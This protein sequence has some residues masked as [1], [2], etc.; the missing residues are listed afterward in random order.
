H[1]TKAVVHDPGVTAV[2]AGA[3]DTL[4]VDGS[5]T[6]VRAWDDLK[7]RIEPTLTEGRA[8]RAADEIALGAK[9]LDTTGAHVGGYVSVRGRGVV[10]RMHVVGRVVLPS[11]KFNKLGYGGVMTFAA[12][13]RLDSGAQPGLYLMR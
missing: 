4:S 5:D 13:K 11:S 7:G 2:G 1:V 3:D 12:L 8:P 10:R 9:T 6:G